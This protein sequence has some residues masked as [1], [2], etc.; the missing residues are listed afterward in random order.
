MLSEIRKLTRVG[1]ETTSKKF[2]FRFA[3][4]TGYS[5]SFSLRIK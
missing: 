1:D 4:P 3:S 5:S 2:C